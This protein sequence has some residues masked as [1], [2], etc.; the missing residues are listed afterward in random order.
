MNL[1]LGLKVYDDVSAQRLT[2]AGYDGVILGDI[3]CDRRM[4]SYGS[5]D[6]IQFAYELS[7]T[8]LELIYQTPMYL[9]D[10]SFG[11]E[12]IR[13]GH[14]YSG[15]GV[16]KLLVQDHGLAQWLTQNLPDVEII[17]SRMGRNR[18]S[19]M[20]QIFVDFLKDSGVRSIECDTPERMT[21]LSSSGMKVYG[22]YGALKYNTLSRECYH[23]YLNDRYDGICGR[24]CLLGDQHLTHG[25]FS[26]SVDGYMLG[27][28]KEYPDTKRFVE[29]AAAVDMD[30]MVYVDSLQQALCVKKDICEATRMRG[31]DR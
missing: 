25:G 19:L 4:F 14:L 20:N 30:V 23:M 6:M 13:I 24:E 28:K 12:I 8:S 2:D 9:T 10:R 1:Y 22:V 5:A 27:E 15:S 17:W 31:E 18:N 11:D 29:S 26:M 21:A 16:R 7:H 3:L